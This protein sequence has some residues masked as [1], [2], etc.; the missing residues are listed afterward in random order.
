VA[1]QQQVEVVFTDDLTG[2]TLREA[3]V[4]TVSFAVDNIT[5]EI[6]LCEKNASS[7]RN[8]FAA[9]VEHARPLTATATTRRSSRRP[10]TNTP[11]PSADRRQ[12]AKIRQWAQSNGHPVSTRGRLPAEVVDAYNA[13][14]T[15]GS[16]TEPAAP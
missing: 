10:T 6:D 2:D 15:L 13:T 1:R 11:Q 3:D 8:D 14:T 5:Y 16:N 7:M 4:Q 12:T 9:W